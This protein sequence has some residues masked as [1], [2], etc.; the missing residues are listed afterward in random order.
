[1]SSA[2]S[3]LQG[4]LAAASFTASAAHSPVAE[5]LRVVCDVVID[6]SAR[7]GANLDAL[8]SRR[9]AALEEQ[10]ADCADYVAVLSAGGRPPISAPEIRTLDVLADQL[11]TSLNGVAGDLLL[12]ERRPAAVAPAQSSKLSDVVSGYAEDARRERRAALI[13]FSIA[14]ALV[15]AA[16]G[17]VIAGL[18]QIASLNRNR[19]AHPSWVWSVFSAYLIA[20]LVSLI[21]A[22]IL[23]LLGERHRHAAQESTRLSRQ[24]DVVESYLAPMSTQAR[25]LIRASL[26]PRLFSRILSDD[27]PMREPIWPTAEDVANTRPTRRTTGSRHAASKRRP[28]E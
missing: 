13:Y 15:I 17:V 10:L 25:D 1:M 23:I 18:V 7:F 28:S 6:L 24:F 9:F 11:L 14:T 16:F 19:A 22:G 20:S 26:T 4:S 3:A 21:A 2:A 12:I 27:D 5:K 8:W